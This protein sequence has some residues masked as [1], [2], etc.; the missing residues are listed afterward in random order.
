[1]HK[2]QIG[3]NVVL[4]RSLRLAGNM[5]PV[6]AGWEDPIAWGPAGCGRLMGE[7]DVSSA[8]VTPPGAMEDCGRLDVFG[9]AERG[10]V[11]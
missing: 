8:G 7:I 11:L 10:G 2:A 3:V 1:M 5:P 9:G 6:A 4:V